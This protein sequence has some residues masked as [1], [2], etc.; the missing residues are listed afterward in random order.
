MLIIGIETSSSVGSVAVARENGDSPHFSEETCFTKGLRHGANVLPAIDDLFTK[1]ALERAEVGLICVSVGPGS[2]T[3]IRVGLAAAKGLAFALDAPLV[4][5]PAPDAII[6]NLDP[7]GC[8]AVI[9]DARREQFY[10]T[11]YTASGDDWKPDCDHAVLPPDDAAKLLAP[12]TLLVGEGV[13]AFLAVTEGAWHR[14]PEDA[15]IPHASWT[16]R[17]GLASHRAHPRNELHTVEP[18]YLRL[19]EAEE[20]WQSK[21]RL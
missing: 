8:A 10:I 7:E 6:R 12:E 20:T 1:H 11:P 18:L 2:Y 5:V 21:E 16:V 4:G 14:A 9:I 17:L 3:G 13:D 19:C 15:G